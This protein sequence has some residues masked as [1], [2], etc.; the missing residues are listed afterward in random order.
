LSNIIRF[1]QPSAFEK[2]ILQTKKIENKA[3]NFHGQEV[4]P[5][6]Q[7]QFLF[8]EIESL[9]KQYEALQTEIKTAQDQAKAEIDSW[10]QEKQQRAEQEA[11][12]LAEQAKAQGFQAGFDQG[13]LEA[14]EKFRQQNQEMQEL[15]GAAYE[16]KAKIIQQA[17]PFLLELSIK[18]SEKIIKKELKQHDDQLMNIVKH[19]LRRVEESEDVVMQVSL[20]DYPIIIPYLEELKTYIRADSE[21][22]L[23]PVANLT[24]GG[25]MIHTASGSYDVT[26]TGQL[27][28]IKRQ[29]LAYSEEKTSDEPAER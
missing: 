3:L 14:E 15:I 25:C 18:I 21:L 26:V 28:E 24:K 11:Q 10:W 19:A 1:Q 7:Q 12:Q 5:G 23:I 20:E 13:V 9:K 6:D 2:K 22:K 17:E 4:E 16:E 27:E 8:Q 29:L